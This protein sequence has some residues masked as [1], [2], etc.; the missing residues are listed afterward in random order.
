MAKINI[1]VAI[2]LIAIAV[3]SALP[4]PK[5]NPQPKPQNCGDYYPNY[6]YYPYPYSAGYPVYNGG[7]QNYPFYNPG[8]QSYP[9]YYSGGYF[10]QNP[11]PYAP[12][13]CGCDSQP[14][15][16]VETIPVQEVAYAEPCQETVLVV[17]SCPEAC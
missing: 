5:P 15:Y 6:P 9:Y 2:A 3:A 14:L 10:A 12:Y 8:Y 1:I 17:E 11:I 16:V 7:Y 4:A 13:G